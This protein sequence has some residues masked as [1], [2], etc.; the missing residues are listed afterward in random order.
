[1]P[2][3]RPTL[4]LSRLLPD[5]VMVIVRKQFQLVQE[6]VDAL[7]TPSALREGLCQ[8]DVAIVTLG[9]RIDAEIIHAAT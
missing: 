8:A 2:D 5:P 6:P 9:D 7:P 1:M 4:Y 3:A